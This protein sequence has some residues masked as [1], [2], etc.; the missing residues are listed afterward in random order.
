[1]RF[2]FAPE[3]GACSDSDR[4][5]QCS[6]IRIHFSYSCEILFLVVVVRST[7][8]E[9]RVDLSQN[10]CA[11]LWVAFNL[12]RVHWA[13]SLVLNNSFFLSRVFTSNWSFIQ[14]KQFFDDDENFTIHWSSLYNLQPFEKNKNIL[15]DWQ[16]QKIKFTF[17]SPLF[18]Y[19]IHNISHNFASTHSIQFGFSFIRCYDI[20]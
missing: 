6:D 13:F 12:R 1:M 19:E 15:F 3:D 14:Q 11:V 18:S 10:Y 9:S 5:L 8:D 7:N 16:T 20:N 4:V 2:F 17:F